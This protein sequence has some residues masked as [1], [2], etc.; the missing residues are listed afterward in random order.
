MSFL[1]GLCSPSGVQS[2]VVPR[3]YTISSDGDQF[4]NSPKRKVDVIR[5][6][7]QPTSSS[8]ASHLSSKISTLSIDEELYLFALDVKLSS[9]TQFSVDWLGGTIEALSAY[10]FDQNNTK[11]V[12]SLI[13]LLRNVVVRYKNIHYD[14]FMAPSPDFSKSF[15][16]DARFGSQQLLEPI[17]SISSACKTLSTLLNGYLTN[18][19]SDKRISRS[20]GASSPRNFGNSFHTSQNVLKIAVSNGK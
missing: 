17:P 1:F 12:V 15:I 6:K 9:S 16:C 3:K 14:G 8:D 11:S 13:C 18:G 20:V 19:Q 7:P 5:L 2:Q 10:T 4:D